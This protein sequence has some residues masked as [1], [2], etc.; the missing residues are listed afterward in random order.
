MKG[1]S[2]PGFRIIQ[3]Y[4]PRRSEGEFKENKAAA[5]DFAPFVRPPLRGENSFFYRSSRRE[6]L[7]E[8]LEIGEKK[9]I[10]RFSG[11]MEVGNRIWQHVPFKK[12]LLDIS[13]RILRELSE[14]GNES[15]EA[16]S[17]YSNLTF[18]FR[19]L[20]REPHELVLFHQAERLDN[21]T[22]DKILEKADPKDL[23]KLSRR[24]EELQRY[25]RGEEIKWSPGMVWVVD[26]VRHGRWNQAVT[27][28][29][30]LEA[31]EAAKGLAY[32]LDQFIKN[33][34]K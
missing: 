26:S 31:H 11:M 28:A 13:E 4:E 21:E 20:A 8:F 10:P 1:K 7:K 2:M 29:A 30:F 6:G 25:I 5:H 18:I 9:P 33:S 3:K 12:K 22:H 14:A 24:S 15:P 32:V 23:E 34:G 17:G 16:L 19:S 27:R